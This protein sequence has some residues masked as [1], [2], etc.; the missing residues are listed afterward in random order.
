MTFKEGSRG[1]ERLVKE[2]ECVGGDE[3]KKI[4][5]G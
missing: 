3:E 4:G 2:E 5:S 1:E